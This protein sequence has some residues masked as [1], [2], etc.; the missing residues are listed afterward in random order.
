MNEPPLSKIC[1]V[2]DSGL[3]YFSV[4]GFFDAD[5]DDFNDTWDQSVIRPVNCPKCLEWKRQNDLS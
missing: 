3:P 1:F 5:L 4:C 2:P